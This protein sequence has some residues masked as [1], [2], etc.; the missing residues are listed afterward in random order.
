MT[1]RLMS[2]NEANETFIKRVLI[3]VMIAVAALTIWLLLPL[4]LLVFG[5]VLLALTLRT[6]AWPLRWCGLNE[7]A[8]VIVTALITAVGLI[9]AAVLFGTEIVTQ[10]K[11]LNERAGITLSRLT[12]F[13]GLQPQ[14]IVNGQS[15]VASIAALIPR[16]LSFGWTVGQAIA[17]L[18]FVVVASVYL[19]L[20]P[21]P[22]RDGLV[23]LVPYDYK[24]NAL[25]TLDDIG[26]GLQHWLGGTLLSM[27][28]VGTLTGVGLWLVGVQSPLALGLLAGAANFVP[29]IGSIVAAAVTVIMAAG[30]SFDAALA[31][32]GVLLVIQQIESY[33]L[34]PLVVGRAVF[35]LP[36]TGMFAMFA[37]AL[38]FG[39]LGVIFG[40]PLAIV[41]DIAIRRLYVRHTLDE[42]VEILGQPAQRSEVA[43]SDET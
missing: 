4:V 9:V 15:P 43:V 17:G 38:L 1:V 32:A 3:A 29:Y 21:K 20:D 28:I 24:Q 2:N 41:A 5:S 33:I 8:A 13:L 30:Q 22:Y 35:I 10:L 39:P 11:G 42:P 34:A 7:G 27:V 36:A 25:A 12:A 16:F 23:K 40:F 31:A 37:M 19:A 26:E 14:D 6:L 18:L